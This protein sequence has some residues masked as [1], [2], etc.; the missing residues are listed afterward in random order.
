MIINIYAEPGYMPVKAEPH[1]RGWDCF[2]YIKEVVIVNPFIPTIIPLGF[3]VASD[4]DLRAK[5]GLTI[6]LGMILGNAPG[7][8]ECSYPDMVGAIVIN[9]SVSNNLIISPGDVICQLLPANEYETSELRIFP[10]KMALDQ[11]RDGFQSSR[12]GGFG[13]ETAK[14][15]HS[16]PILIPC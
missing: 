6:N 15:K 7:T 12:T 14:A 2:A 3:Y 11:L 5:S 1:S 8:I 16:K 13:N 10:N 4:I 9:T